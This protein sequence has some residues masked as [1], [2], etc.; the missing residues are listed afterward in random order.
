M[1]KLGLIVF[2]LGLHAHAGNSNAACGAMDNSMLTSVS[3]PSPTTKVQ[4]LNQPRPR[5]A[6]SPAQK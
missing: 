1:K 4:P 2:I 5:Q 6:S 3:T